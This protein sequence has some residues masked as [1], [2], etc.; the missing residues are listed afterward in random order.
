MFFFFKKNIY[1]YNLN[2]IFFFF[3]KKKIKKK[4]KKYKKKKI[5][6]KNLIKNI[7]KYYGSMI[8]LLLLITIFCIFGCF[9]L[10]L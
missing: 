7:K 3:L 2:F 9:I 6:E 4:K 5:K 10:N 8:Y 1:I